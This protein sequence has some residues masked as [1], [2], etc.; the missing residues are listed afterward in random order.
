MRKRTLLV[1]LCGV[2]VS[3]G[4]I[5]HLFAGSQISLQD[6]APADIEQAN[7]EF[8]AAAS[9][10]NRAGH[11]R[12]Q[13]FAE[14]TKGS[15]KHEGFITLHEKDQHLYAE[16]KPMQLEQ[17]ILAPMVIARGSANAGQPLNFGD[18]WVLVVPPGRRQPPAHPQEHP[19]HRPG[20]HARWRRR[21]SRIT[22]T[23]S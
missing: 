11:G 4:T 20:G 10:I 7:V 6:P 19:L 17:P 5:A 16:I 14:L 15:K 2:M 1:A 22:P 12:L 23:R 3:A 21:S 13:D 18:E 8:G 9:G